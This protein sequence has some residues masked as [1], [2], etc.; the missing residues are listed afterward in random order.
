MDL[1]STNG[2]SWIGI[3]APN[4]AMVVFALVSRKLSQR[5]FLLA[6]AVLTVA[7][8]GTLAVLFAPNGNLEDWV[9]AGVLALSLLAAYLLFLLGVLDDSPTL[10]LVNYVADR[11]TE[12]LPTTEIETFLRER[13]F[14]QR[15]IAAL[16]DAGLVD[17]H[18]GLLSL[19]G[20]AG[21]LREL[22]NRYRT[23]CR[24]SARSG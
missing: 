13:S 12:G 10:A 5:T 2:I 18:D 7:S 20:G 19:R 9:L 17:I 15:R 14:I 6:P 22:G 4:A 11:G 23:M 3:A 16:C 8:F 21:V 1:F 24:R